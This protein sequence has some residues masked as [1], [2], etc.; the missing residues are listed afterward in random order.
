[1]IDT[2][3][4][5]TY[6]PLFD[7]LD[8]VLARAA[9]AGVEQMITVGT[10]PQDAQRAV[11]L[12]GRHKHLFATVG[13]HPLHADQSPDR[14][15]VVDCVRALAGAGQVVALGEMGLDKHY[16]EPPLEMQRRVLDWQLELAGEFPDLPMIIH[17]R[18]ATDELIERLSA[19]GLAGER[20]VFHCF[21]GTPAEA[22]KILA[23]GASI[24]FTGIVT[25]KNAL[26]VAEAARLT[27]LDRLLCET[28][29]PYLTPEPHRKVRPNEPCYVPYVAR[30]IAGIRGLAEKELIAAADANARRIFRLP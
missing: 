12:A 20:F 23:L 8:A 13:V 30:H 7:Q 28:D 24:G 29:S 10:S 19:S 22:E 1:M 6:P 15:A 9:G 18:K 14:Q 3:C 25:F 26:E 27:P 11:E 5:L 2:H 16:A 21:T 4:H 17:N